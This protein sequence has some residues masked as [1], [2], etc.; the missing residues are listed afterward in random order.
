MKIMN[1]ILD[2]ELLIQNQ[3]SLSDTIRMALYQENS[4]LFEKLNYEDDATFLEPTLFCYF[5]SDISSKDKIPLAQTILG[6]VEQENWPQ[7]VTLKA[8]IF[9]LINLPNLGY[10][11]ANINERKIIE[12][13]KIKEAI[14]P[15]EYVPNSLLRLCLHPTDLL[16]YQEGVIFDE[17]IEQSL[18]K[19]KVALLSATHFFQTYLPEF[20]QIIEKVTRELVV[21]SSPNYNS[22]AGIMQH[23]TAYFNV[24]N[25]CQT[26]VFF[27]DDIAHQC[28]HVVFNALTLQTDQ[29]L[30]VP[31]D[32]SM[33]GYTDRQG[34]TR[35]AYG[36]FHGLFTYTTILYS[37]D[38]ILDLGDVLDKDGRHEAM[39]RIGFYFEKFGYDLQFIRNASIL[40]ET[41]MDY[42]GQFAEGFQYISKKYGTA[43]A[44][45]DYSNQPY[46]FQ[47][48]LF[49]ELNPI[50][51]T[52][53]A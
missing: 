1:F 8:D 30:K 47:Y 44:T 15:Y 4:E 10:L 19:N 33:K 34:E 42:W 20:W 5:L 11:Q 45:L 2:F 38:K 28:G 26:S 53:T 35:G 37:L 17:P 36:A 51:K 32:H 49:K 12:T 13:A 14:I 39:G 43:L 22:F 16:A 52:V 3:A 18:I 40:T 48:D 6:Y 46:M 25:K 29:F 7:T 50:Q 27:I 9:G 24:E 41:G 21:F 23:G 31:K